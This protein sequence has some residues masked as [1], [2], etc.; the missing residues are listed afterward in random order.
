MTVGELDQMSLE[1]LD[2]WKAL[3]ALEREEAEH[4]RKRKGG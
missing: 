4:E 1:E 2:H 3:Y